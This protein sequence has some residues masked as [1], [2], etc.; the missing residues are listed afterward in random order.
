MWRVPAWMRLSHQEAASTCGSKRERSRPSISLS[1]QESLRGSKL[2]P[3]APSSSFTSSSDKFSPPP[4]RHRD[5]N[6][7]FGR[8]ILSRKNRKVLFA[9]GVRL[10]SLAMHSLGEVSNFSHRNI[11]LAQHQFFHKFFASPSWNSCFHISSRIVSLI[12]SFHGNSRSLVW[13]ES[14][15]SFCVLEMIF[16]CYYRWDI[17]NVPRS[18]KKT[19]T[20]PSSKLILIFLFY[21]NY[22]KNN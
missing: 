3:L 13:G 20:I 21:K 4:P 7:I 8:M 11:S 17:Q 5:V 18:L 2:F 14:F 10:I 9:C 12:F 15:R 19:I 6:A 22:S 1:P 16:L